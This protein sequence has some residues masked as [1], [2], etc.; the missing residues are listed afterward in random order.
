MP[1]LFFPLVVDQCAG[2]QR[3]WKVDQR[4]AGRGV[5]RAVYYPGPVPPPG[6]TLLPTPGTP[7]PTVTDNPAASLHSHGQPG[8]AL[9]AGYSLLARSRN[10]VILSWPAPGPELF[11]LPRA[12]NQKY[13]SFRGQRTRGITSEVPDPVLDQIAQIPLKDP[14]KNGVILDLLSF[15]AWQRVSDR[16]F[17]DAQMPRRALS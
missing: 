4:C 12:E 17:F 7:P 16:S 11:L 13:S 6:Y 10:R 1:G 14:L 3:L 2:S 8:P 15:P 9:G 5:P